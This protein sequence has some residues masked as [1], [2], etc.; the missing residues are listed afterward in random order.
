MILSIALTSIGYYSVVTDGANNGY[1]YYDLS[2]TVVP[3]SI[4][5]MF[6]LKKFAL[7]FINSTT[8]NK[9]ALLSF[10]IYL[11]HPAILT[12]LDV[13]GIQA[14]SFNPLLSIPL[15]S[16]LIFTLAIIVSM[17]VGKMPILNRIIGFR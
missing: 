8:S 16:V 5:M 15:L 12:V 1:F 17:I 3:M 4:S 10:G 6:L 13:S 9:L 7:P 14:I 2:I 11:I